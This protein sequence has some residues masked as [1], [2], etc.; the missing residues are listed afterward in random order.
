V[1]L[2]G[3]GRQTRDFVYVQDVVE[4]MLR[5]A[6]NPVRRRLY[7]VGTGVEVSIGAM[8]ETVQ[9]L[10]ARRVPVEQRDAWPN[11]IQR[12]CA[13]VSRL[14]EDFGFSPGVTLDQGL[15]ETIDFFRTAGEA[16]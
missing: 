7:N 13:D 14:R 9:R 15:Q 11:D 5:V 6:L 2:F 4:A 1:E 10:S 12:I 8:L 16:Y 3:D